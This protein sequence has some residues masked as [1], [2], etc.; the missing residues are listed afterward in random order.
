MANHFNRAETKMCVLAF[1]QKFLAKIYEN[2]HDLG[3]NIGKIFRGNEQM[4]NFFKGYSKNAEPM[5]ENICF[6]EIFRTVH[7]F[8][9]IN[10]LD[11]FR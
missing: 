2:F 11:D 8:A 5:I 6:K 1:L 7:F 3:E 9:K 10:S 4:L